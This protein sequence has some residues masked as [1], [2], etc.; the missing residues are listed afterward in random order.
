MIYRNKSKNIWEIKKKN[1]LVSILRNKVGI[2]RQKVI[3][4]RNKGGKKSILFDQLTS[5]CYILILISNIGLKMQN[6][7]DYFQGLLN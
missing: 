6:K 5:S 2:M 4:S 7:H 1:Y 3:I